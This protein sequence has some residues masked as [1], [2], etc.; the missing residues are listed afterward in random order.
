MLKL[1]KQKATHTP[2]ISTASLPDIVFMLLF[3]FMTVTVMKDIPLKVSNE[4][5]SASEVKKL[6]K[7]DRVIYIHIGKPNK[8]Y[9]D[10]WGAAPRIQLNDKFAKVSD[11]GPY[12]LGK[13]N[14]MPEDL[15]G[16]VTISLKVDKDAGM[17]II[18]D[19]KEELRKVYTLKVNYTT[20]EME[21]TNYTN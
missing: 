2:E 7:K 8:A 12:V 15:R 5:P 20:Y 17:G 4:L 14:L 9:T 3:F 11:I 13:M 1:Q 16:L 10:L 18:S 19:V 21:E 6:E